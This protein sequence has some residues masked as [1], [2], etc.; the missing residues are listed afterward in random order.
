MNLYKGNIT[1]GKNI[2][3]VFGINPKGKHGAGLAEV[4]R[5]KFGAL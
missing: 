5:Q 1:P 3:F 2:V 4:T